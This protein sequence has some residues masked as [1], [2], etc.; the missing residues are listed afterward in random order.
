MTD[1]EWHGDEVQRQLGIVVRRAIAQSGVAFQREVKR[2]VN[3]PGT[4]R[5]YKKPSGR[6]HQA[7]APGEP[8]AKDT[9]DYGR[10]IQLDARKLKHKTRPSVRVGTLSD[11]GPWLEFGTLRI[12]RRPHFRPT[13][14]KFRKQLTGLLG[15][16]IRFG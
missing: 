4:G 1:V 13:I 6:L 10:S 2:L 3:R 16:I 8:P 15:R 11:K 9:G 12:K 14:K 7:S 5:V